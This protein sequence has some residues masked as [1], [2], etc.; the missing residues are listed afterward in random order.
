[1]DENTSQGM[2]GYSGNAGCCTKTRSKQTYSKKRKYHCGNK[3]RNPNDKK[4]MSETVSSQFDKL[5][6]TSTT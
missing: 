2:K 5:N 1:M 3:T 4:P 6:G